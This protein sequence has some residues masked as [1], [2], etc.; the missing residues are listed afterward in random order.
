MTRQHFH[1]LVQVGIL[2]LTDF[3]PAGT[4]NFPLTECKG[5]WLPESEQKRLH[6]DR[7]VEE[8]SRRLQGQ[9]LLQLINTK[10]DAGFF[11]GFPDAGGQQ[12]MILVIFSAA[13]KGEVAGPRIFRVINSSKDQKTLQ[14]RKTSYDCNGGRCI[15]RWRRHN[16]YKKRIISG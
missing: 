4:L 10:M 11:S 6:P 14:R 9:A 1:L 3:E 15:S 7:I 13:G 8:V 5:G 2:K 12:I 16:E